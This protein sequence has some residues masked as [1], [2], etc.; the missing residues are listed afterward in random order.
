MNAFV[1]VLEKLGIT[2]KRPETWPHEAKF[3]TIHWDSGGYY[4]LC[5]RD[6]LLV[7]GDH[8]I[9]TPNVI[10][11]RAQETFSYRA[12]M[13]DYLKS[14]A[15][16]CNAPKPMLLDS[17]FEVDPD[18]PTPRNGEPAFD[19]ANV[20]RLGQDLIYLVS[21]TGNEMGGKWL[22]TILGDAYRVH[23]LKDVYYGSNYFNNRLRGLL[24]CDVCGVE[25]VPL[26]GGEGAARADGHL[27]IQLNGCLWRL[28][29]RERTASGRNTVAHRGLQPLR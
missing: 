21:G 17:L 2:V 5:P 8:I 22:Q 26:G 11:S 16:W 1:D 27:P 15:K 29:P 10:R 14:G 4:N 28:P 24:W 18:K 20:L 6:I 13:V 3:S 9:E 12:M 7:I 19:A 23:F 25:A